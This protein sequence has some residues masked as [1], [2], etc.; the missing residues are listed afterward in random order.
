MPHLDHHLFL[1]Q[2]LRL[3]HRSQD[4][5]RE[6]LVGLHPAS[7]YH[8]GTSDRRQAGLVGVSMLRPPSEF[9]HRGVDLDGGGRSALQALLAWGTHGPPRGELDRN[10]LPGILQIAISP[11]PS[12][13]PPPP[14]SDRASSWRSGKPPQPPAGC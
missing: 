3:R 6:L 10:R 14:L 4:R 2:P 9:A 13:L 7:E 8:L 5:N 12:S 1:L 11:P